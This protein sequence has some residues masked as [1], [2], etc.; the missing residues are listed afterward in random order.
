MSPD[1]FKIGKVTFLFKAGDTADLGNYRPMSV[2][3]CLL[4]MLERV[5]YNCL[6]QNLKNQET[7]Y[8]KQF[9][10][11]KDNSIDHALIQLVDHIH[12][13]F[14]K[15]KYTLGIFVDLSKAFDTV[16]HITFVRKLECYGIRENNL[17]WF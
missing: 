7:F 15:N 12:D 9:G 14:E 5:M 10:F 11:H 8:P 6:Y 3:P 2:L 4:K 16:G 13:V 1:N 17:K